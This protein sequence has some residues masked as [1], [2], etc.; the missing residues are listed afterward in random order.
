MV[1]VCLALVPAQHV[2]LDAGRLE[3]MQGATN[4]SS[5]TGASTS[6]ATYIP[7]A[8]A[9]STVP[10]S[11]GNSGNLICVVILVTTAPG[12]ECRRLEARS[13]T[14]LLIQICGASKPS[15]VAIFV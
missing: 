3:A 12:V 2:D 5:A 11:H 1:G 14:K 15:R 10:S 7:P 13:S 8:L 6:S 4:R 9:N